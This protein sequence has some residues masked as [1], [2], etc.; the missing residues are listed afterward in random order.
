MSYAIGNENVNVGT[1]TKVYLD[2]T[3]NRSVIYPMMDIEFIMP[4]GNFSAK[5]T[6]CRARI[7]SAGKNLP[8]V[9]PEWINKQITYE[10]K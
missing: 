5:F 7:L 3:T 6:V 1:A 9:T 2:V 4:V 10:S 8:C